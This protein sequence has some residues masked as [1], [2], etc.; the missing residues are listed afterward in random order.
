[1]RILVTADWHI[2]LWQRSYRDLLN[3]N[4][5]V[6]KDLDALIVGGDLANHPF[7]NWQSVLKQ[8]GRLIDPSKVYIMAGN[9]D[10]YHWDL[11]GD[12]KLR[13]F[14]EDAGMTFAQKS[15]FVLGGVRFLCCTLWSDFALTGDPHGA[16][17]VGSKSMNDYQLIRV[18]GRSASPQ[19]TLRVHKDHLTWL[20][21]AMAEP[22]DG[23]TVI[24]T[25]HAPSACATGAID[26]LTPSFTSNLDA[27]ILQHSPHL[28][29]FGHTHR[30]LQGRVGDTPIVNVSVGYPSEV[31]AAREG[32]ILSRGL[33]DTATPHLLVND[34]GG[35]Q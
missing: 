1:M 21:E 15:S 27:W 20:S 5:S 28:W 22:F 14:A 30:N 24:V 26:D 7:Q 17:I 13:A 29:L 11:D 16:M 6:F 10:Y 9:H 25:H 23:R 2:D 33:L 32:K 18:G 12:D 8:I 35:V 31:S 19:D 34:L 3:N 4:R